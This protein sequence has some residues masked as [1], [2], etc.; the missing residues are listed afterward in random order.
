MKEKKRLPNS[1]DIVVGESVRAHRLRAGISQSELAGRLGVSFQ[2]VQ[3][4]EK[5]ADRIGARRLYQIAGIFDIPV[6]TLL[7]ANANEP[8]GS[9]SAVSAKLKPDGGTRELLSAF[10]DIAHLGISHH[11]VDLV[12]AI[13]K[14]TPRARI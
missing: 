5:G 14:V 9:A 12:N 2:Q 1:P 6:R 3:Q 10:G 4:Y 11:L 13:A 8:G 7:G